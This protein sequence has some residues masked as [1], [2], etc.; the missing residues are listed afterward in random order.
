MTPLSGLLFQQPPMANRF[1]VFYIGPRFAKLYHASPRSLF[2]PNQETQYAENIE[3]KPPLL[4]NP[5]GGFKVPT[6]GIAVISS[7]RHIGVL[8]RDALVS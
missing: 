4:G 7:V 6:S 2:R 5:L 3:F 1:S 8:L